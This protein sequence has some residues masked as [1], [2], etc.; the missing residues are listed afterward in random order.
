MR[1]TPEG[2][3]LVPCDGPDDV[4]VFAALQAETQPEM[5]LTAEELAHEDTLTPAGRRWLARLDGD[6]V[7]AGVSSI[8][9][10]RPPD[11][12][13]AWTTVMVREP[14]RR[15][16]IGGALLETI[17]AHARVMGKSALFMFATDE[18]PDA[19]EFLR[20][21]GFEERERVK[22]V[23][24]ALAGLDRPPVA[25]PPGVEV[26][27]LAERPA[28]AEGIYA[29]ALEAEPDVPTADPYEVEPI[30]RWRVYALD[31]P[32]E[33][34]E[35]CFVALA[36]DEVVGWAN[37][38]LPAARPGVGYHAMTGVKRAWRGR[39]VASTL[40]RATIAWAVTNGLEALETE[41]DVTNAPMRA[42]NRRLGYEPLP[43]RVVL[44]A[45]LPPR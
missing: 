18:R 27:T 17:A 4:A 30:E 37:L 35:A 32:D 22:Y 34:H 15:R 26:V 20:H 2:L 6:V 36:G 16:G 44:R 38:G 1:R 29:A 43:D 33:P 5:A 3:E 12:E 13:G 45:E 9:Y 21:R 14:F 8:F 25:P 19:V 28:L 24:L 11:F 23:A 41:N 40:K 42:I 39:G 10:A 7:G 31:M